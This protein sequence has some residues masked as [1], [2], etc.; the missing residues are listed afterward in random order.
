M[1]KETKDDFAYHVII[2][3]RKLSGLR[4]INHGEYLTNE[5]TI[6]EVYTGSYYECQC[7]YE[8][9]DATID[10]PIMVEEEMY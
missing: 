6:V 7:F 3:P 4:I 8:T 5:N 2:D 9:Y 10:Y 1:D